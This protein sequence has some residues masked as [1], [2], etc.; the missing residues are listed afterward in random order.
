[1]PGI[2]RD[3]EKARIGPYLITPCFLRAP[4]AL[5][6]QLCSAAPEPNVL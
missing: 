4:A 6:A 2:Q 5:S 1:V 3:A